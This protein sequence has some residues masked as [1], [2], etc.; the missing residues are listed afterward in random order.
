MKEELNR[1]GFSFADS[2]T[3]FVFATHEKLPAEEIFKYLKEKNIYVRYWNKPRI[4]NHLRISVG[5][6]EEA[7]ILINEL[8]ELLG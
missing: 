6:D 2:K 8:E 7:K 5:T 3:N 1:L 4:N